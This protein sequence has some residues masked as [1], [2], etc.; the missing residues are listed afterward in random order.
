MKAGRVAAGLLVLVVVALVA[1]SMRSRF[2]FDPRAFLEQFRRVYFAD[3]LLAVAL[4]YGT[5]LLRSWRW[6][7]FLRAHQPVHPLALTGAQFTGFSAV[8]IF[9]RIADLSRPY[10]IARKTGVPLPVQLAIYTIERMFDLGAAALVFSGALLFASH[11]MPHRE[12]FLRVGIG[13]FAGTLLLAGLAVAIRVGGI[14]FAA[15]AGQLASRVS[16]ALGTPVQER[17][18]VFRTGLAAIRSGL[19]FAL[20]ALLSITIVLMVALAYR[21]TAHAFVAEPTLSGLDMTRTMLLVAASIGGSLLQLPVLGWLTQIATT[22]GVMR[23][24]FGTPLAPATACGALLLFVSWLC[25]IPVGFFF[26]QQQGIGLRELTG[27]S[28]TLAEESREQPTTLKDP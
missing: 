8:A 2:H 11:G 26:A 28:D 19:D 12:L 21:Q 9:G 3:I 22:A 23:G 5:Y 17:I 7:I 1:Y 13:S 27:K 25:V 24:L 20:T 14:R 18:L 6:A 10:L 16:P 15:L 4:I